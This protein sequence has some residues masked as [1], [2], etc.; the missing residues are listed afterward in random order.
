[1]KSEAEETAVQTAGDVVEQGAILPYVTTAAGL[2]SLNLL[3]EGM[4]CGGCVNR[5]ETGLTREPGVVEARANLTT[6]RLS[7][8][9]RDEVCDPEYLI[10]KAEALGFRLV[11]FDPARLMGGDRAAERELL[12]AMAISGFAAAN[13]M[14]LSVSV[15]AGHF[16]DMGPATRSLMHWLS[17]LV[18]LPAIAYAGIPFFRSAWRAVKAYRLNMDVPITLAV[19]LASGMSLFQTMHGGEHAYFDSAIMLLFFLLVGRYLDRRARGRARSAVENL[20]ALTAHAVT[21]V[22][23][24]GSTRSAAVETLPVKAQVQV[25]PGERIAVDGAIDQGR[26]DI[27]A[28]LINGESTPV[29]VKPG[30]TVYAG[31][32]NLTGSLRITVRAVGEGTLLAEIARLMAAAESRRSG[33]VALA[34]RMVKYYAPAVHIAAL[35][36]FIGWLSLSSIPWLTALTY[37]IAVLIVTCPCALALAV[38]VVQVVASGDLMR[39][40]ILLKSGQALE[41]IAGVDTVIFDKTGTLTSGRPELIVDGGWNREDLRHAV[42][43]ALAS[44]HPLARSLAGML[45]NAQLASRVEEMPGSGL[46]RHGGLGEERLGSRSWCHVDSDQ[47]VT[48]PEL[49]FTRPGHYPVRFSFRD[50]L[51]ADAA[52]V[53]RQLKTDGYHVEI[54]SGDRPEAVT[55]ISQELAIEHWQAACSPIDKVAYLEHLRGRGRRVCMVGDGLND[56]PALAAAAVSISPS[57]AADI[58]QTTADVVF[59]GDSLRS[60]LEV[61]RKARFADRLVRQNFGLAFGYNLITVPLAMAG[62]VTP[63]IA[64]IAMSGSSIAVVLNALRL[65]WR[66]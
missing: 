35:A 51:R 60:V 16:Q 6:R 36:T 3:V 39:K 14:L 25:A 29:K 26:S 45:P 12:R 11:P 31:M 50:H 27:D 48:G 24:D 44:K 59:Q 38:P 56:A 19:L 37:A 17:A 54:L 46:V 1:M 7:L 5:L 42:G 33:R 13:V 32:I 58:S 9:W 34:D 18:A 55:R 65:G 66:R 21:V 43:L 8:V 20:V 57:S 23:A 15:W 2:S 10:T 4:H 28:S 30:D 63:L 62:M 53:V 64:A 22:E 49:W 52:D 41:T 61:F 47:A 40:G